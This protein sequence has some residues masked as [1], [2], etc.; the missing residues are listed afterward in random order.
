[1]PGPRPE[2]IALR[3]FRGN[4]GRR[5]IPRVPQFTTRLSAPPEFLDATA[6]RVWREL[7]KS[8]ATV[9]GLVTAVDAPALALM[10]QAYADAVGF[11]AEV[12]KR[13]AVVTTGRGMIRVN[14]AIAAYNAAVATY[15][16]FAAEFGLTPSAR[17]RVH[18][19]LPHED[20]D[21]LLDQPN[22]TG[23]SPRRSDT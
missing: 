16:K 7:V 14:P 5:R 23:I 21:P 20:D 12:A 4:P 8:M 9:P 13:G 17:S 1:M 10:C 11:R 2:P 15:L 6:K 3:I 22:T 18:L 19:P